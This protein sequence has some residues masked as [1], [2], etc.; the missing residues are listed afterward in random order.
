M[1]VSTTTQATDQAI[2]LHQADYRRVM[3]SALRGNTMTCP[4]CGATITLNDQ[5]KGSC[6]CGYVRCEVSV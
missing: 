6:R 1:N 5:G 2:R 3:D 4:A